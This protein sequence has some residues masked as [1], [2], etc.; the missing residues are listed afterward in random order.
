MPIIAN[1]KSPNNEKKHFSTS[2]FFHEEISGSRRTQAGGKTKT[3]SFREINTL[4]VRCCSELKG[5]PFEQVPLFSEITELQM[6]VCFRGF[7]EC[8]EGRNLDK[9]L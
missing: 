7:T 3:I 8:L 9:G 2:P 4:I 5:K 1:F 6:E